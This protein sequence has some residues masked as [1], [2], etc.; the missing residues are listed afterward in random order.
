MTFVRG[1]SLERRAQSLATGLVLPTWSLLVL[2]FA[3]PLLMAVYLSVRNEQIGGFIPAAFVGIENFRSE[4]SSPIFWEAFRTTLIIMV[5][6]LVLQVP[7]GLGLALALYQQ[8][9]GTRFFRSALLI[10]M[11]LTPVAV[12]L[13]WRFMFD[14]D[15]GVINWLL[16]STGFSAKNWLGMRWPAIWAVA[17]VDSWQSIPFVMLMCIAGLAGLPSGPLEAARIDGASAWQSFWHVVLP[18]LRPVLL[19]TLMIR[20]IDTFKLFDLLFIMTNRGGPG[21]ATQTL[22]MLTYN[23]GFTFLAISRAAALGLS[24]VIIS[25]P[26]YILWR[27][28]SGGRR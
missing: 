21:T 26:I 27:S 10:P 20:V 28:A 23:T 16:E 9:R 13:M 12:G 14:T 6:G 17:L 11:L 7:V 24:L 4:L 19:V 1:Q 2:V 8:L 5:F 25:L 3:L 22:G 18:M 15:L